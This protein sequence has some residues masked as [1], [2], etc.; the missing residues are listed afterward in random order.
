MKKNNCIRHDLLL[1]QLSEAVLN[2]IAENIDL[3]GKFQFS[4]YICAMSFNRTRAYDQFLGNLGVRVAFCDQLK[5]FSFSDGNPLIQVEIQT[6]SG[7]DCIDDVLGNLAAQITLSQADCLYCLND[8]LKVIVFHH[9][10]T[11]AI[12][13]R[14]NDIRG[15]SMDRDHYHG[16]IRIPLVYYFCCFNAIQVRH[17]YVGQDNIRSKVFNQLNHFIT[18]RG[19]PYDFY[20]WLGVEQYRKALPNH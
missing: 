1:L 13:E 18:I 11:G 16:H 5:D 4:H 7:N 8:I 15:G 14:T 20:V 9:V 17:A 19:L 6:C 12:P 2:C 3:R 10:S